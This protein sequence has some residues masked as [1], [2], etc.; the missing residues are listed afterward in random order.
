LAKET[1]LIAI[2]ALIPALAMNIAGIVSG[3]STALWATAIIGL[4]TAYILISMAL[5]CVLLYVMYQGSTGAG[6]KNE[7]TPDGA[8]GLTGAPLLYPASPSVGL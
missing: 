8:S 2:A 3:L 4:I 6:E 5:E 7:D 1:L